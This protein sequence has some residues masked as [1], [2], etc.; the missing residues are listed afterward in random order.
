MTR[1]RV[2]SLPPIHSTKK[3]MKGKWIF[4]GKFLHCKYLRVS[5]FIIMNIVIA[6]KTSYDDN[7]CLPAHVR[8][9]LVCIK[10][11]HN[12]RSVSFTLCSL[13]VEAWLFLLRKK[14]DKRSSFSVS[15][16]CSLFIEFLVF[17]LYMLCM[18]NVQVDE[19]KEDK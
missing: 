2:F 13:T 14:I 5:L 4:R 15:F 1:V 18:Y 17:S 10:K 6:Q 9:K 3:T 7:E 19:D 11:I 12:T 16:V 8:K